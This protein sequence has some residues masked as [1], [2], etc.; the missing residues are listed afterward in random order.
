MTER[1]GD[2]SLTRLRFLFT[3]RVQHVGFRYTACY[4]TRG[5]YVTGWVD[6]LPDGRVMMEVQGPPMQLEK[7][8]SKLKAR[9]EIDRVAVEKL[10]VLPHERGF[11][12]R[13]Y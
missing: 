2:R 6:N 8:L 11:R 4:F 5:L 10:E 7:L 3:G 1:E 9:F 12:V 13:G